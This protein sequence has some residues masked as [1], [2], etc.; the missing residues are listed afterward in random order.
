LVPRGDTVNVGVGADLDG[1]RAS[2]LFFKV[3]K[4]GTQAVP[5]V[6]FLPAVFVP[7]LL[8]INVRMIPA[9]ATT[10]TGTARLGF[11]DYRAVEEFFSGDSLT[12]YAQ[13]G[14]VSTW[15]GLAGRGWKCVR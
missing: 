8:P 11:V 9:G 6:L 14:S 3:L 15:N 10:P 2:P 5:V 7:P 13:S 4:C 1:R 12:C